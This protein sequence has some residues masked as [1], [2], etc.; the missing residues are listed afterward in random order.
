MKKIKRLFIFTIISSLV[1]SC[2]MSNCNDNLTPMF[3]KISYKENELVTFISDSGFIRTDTVKIEFNKVPEQYN[4]T[5]SEDGKYDCKGDFTIMF[6][7]YRILG[8]ATY[9]KSQ[10]YLEES[11][12]NSSYRNEII[13]DYG[14]Y[15]KSDTVNYV[16]NGNTIKSI[17]KYEID[18]VKFNELNRQ[19][20]IFKYCYEYYYSINDYRLL[21]Y[22]IAEGNNKVNWRLK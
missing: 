14:L 19:N 18:S 2:S 21:F 16:Y 7:S 3:E 8:V 13:S 22:S 6:G 20:K 11:F 12:I 10:S 9:Y 4:S 5:G 1:V 17:H 15:K